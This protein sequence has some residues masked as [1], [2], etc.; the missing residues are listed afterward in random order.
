VVILDLVLAGDAA[1]VGTSS[2][3]LLELYAA[4]GRSVVTLGAGGWRGPSAGGHVVH[5][6]DRP[7]LG[8][9]LAAVRDAPAA[10]GFVFRR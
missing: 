8:E 9:L 7:D 2:E 10:R 1:G 3:H 4:S 6:D 5:L